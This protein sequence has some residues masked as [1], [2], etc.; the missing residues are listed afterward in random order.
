VRL[1][2]YESKR[3]LEACG[4]PVPKGQL[5]SSPDGAREAAEGLGGAVV[6]KAQVLATGRGRAGGVRFADTP[7]EAA[8]VARDLLQLRIKGYRVDQLLVEEKLAISQELYVAAAFEERTKGCLMM[9]SEAGG[10]DINEI[11]ATDPGRIKKTSVGAWVGLHPFNAR[12]LAFGLGLQGGTNAVAQQLF[13]GLWDAFVTYDATLA[14]INPL[15]LTTDARLVAADAHIEIEDDSLFRQRERIGAM[16][17]VERDDNAKPPT[18]FEREALAI[19][20]ADYRG[21][22]GRVVDFPGNLGLLIGAGGGSLTLFDAILRNG[23]KP[24]NYCEV[25]GNPPVSKIYRLAKLILSKPGVRGLAVMTNVFSNS[26]VDFLA[27]G[28]IKAM[29]ELGINPATYPLFFRS[30]GAYEDDAYA[31]LRMYGVQYTGR[32][33]PFEEAARRAVRMIDEAQARGDG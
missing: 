12:E 32:E 28:V 4:V 8:E 30:A 17:I 10:M 23:G 18:E 2:E 25:G 3:I 13:L 31:I 27:R 15:V 29:L 19:D 9:A 21:V 11:A 22:A 33:T 20:K 7:S 6:V 14:E 24:A 5:V 26:R 1:F 16:G